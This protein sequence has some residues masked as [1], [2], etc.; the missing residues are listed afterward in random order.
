MDESI[1]HLSP[2]WLRYTN[3][4]VDYAEGTY[5]YSTDGRR[6]LDFTCGIGVTN[7]GHCHPQVVSAAQSQV[8]KLIH[9]QANIVFHKPMLDLVRELRSVVPPQ[10]DSFFFSNSGAEAIEASLKLARHATGRSNIIVFQGGFHGRTVATMSMDTSN[11]IYRIGY[12]PLMAGVFV[13]PFP[14]VYYFGWS[15]DEV[16]T[17][18][19]KQL[20]H[21]LATQTAPEET[22]AVLIEPVLGE[23]GYVPA[24][25]KFLLGLQEI[26][27]EHNILL[28]VD[29]I[30][31]GFGRTGE[32]FGF[33]HFG[34][35][36]DILVI[37]KGLASGFPLSGIV[38][39]SNMME[40]WI[41]G[42]HGGTYGGNAVSCA[43]AA[44]TIRIIREEE[45][46]KNSARLGEILLARLS[47]L[48]ASYPVIGDVRGLGLMVGVEFT[49]KLGDPD[50][51]A[52][53]AIW[54][55]CLD[56]GLMLL[57]CGTYSNIIRWIPPLVIQDSHLDEALDVFEEALRKLRLLTKTL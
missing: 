10:L 52:A 55:H 49:T 3:I 36:P 38:A 40:K 2:V 32:W 35:M 50:K 43:A 46:V 44:A 53:Q 30:Q 18:C 1:E 56:D 39:S 33:Q 6:Y 21:L 31:S 5:I 51:A 27:S 57:T 20:R 47:A 8:A 9:G 54:K 19:L 25:A 12:Q 4:L 41:T 16:T 29:E 48:K 34:I 22:A 7:T 37:A 24:P 13:A 28:I 23:G 15:E 17:F 45:L 26:C 42:S 14:Y 11:P